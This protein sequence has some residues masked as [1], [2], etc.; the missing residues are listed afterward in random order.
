MDGLEG[1]PRVV[2]HDRGAPVHQ[3]LR[4]NSAP[5]VTTRFAGTV[6]DGGVVWCH[7]APSCWWPSLCPADKGR[8]RCDLAKRDGSHYGD[9]RQY[10]A[11]RVSNLTLVGVRLARPPR[12]STIGR[13]GFV[14]VSGTLAITRSQ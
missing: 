12:R 14:R 6:L 9:R 1:A 7:G 5:S 10:G 8:I 13:V 2:T 4:A 3:R 11:C